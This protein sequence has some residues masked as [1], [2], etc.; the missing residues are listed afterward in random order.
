[1]LKNYLIVNEA[2]LPEVFSK[3]VEVKKLLDAGEVT[4]INDAVKQVGVSRSAYYKYKDHVFAPSHMDVVRTALISFVLS[5]IKGVLSRVLN[6]ISDHGGNILTINQ[7]IPIQNKANVIVSIDIK[8]LTTPI[9]QM[10]DDIG[11]IE[12]VSQINLLSME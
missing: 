7:N 9:N 6:D 3:V 10:L 11:M 1:M 12:G 2:I 4:Q 8:G 5:D